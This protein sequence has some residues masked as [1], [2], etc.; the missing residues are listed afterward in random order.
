MKIVLI[1]ADTAT[2]PDIEPL[3]HVVTQQ[4]IKL[5]MWTKSTALQEFSDY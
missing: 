5:T 2:K 4:D 1:T 3:I